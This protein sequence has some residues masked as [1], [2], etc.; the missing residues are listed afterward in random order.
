M[1]VRNGYRTKALMLGA[2]GLI[3][4]LL[5]CL[6]LIEF[7]EASE[8]QS[9]I[10]LIQ[11]DALVSV[12]LVDRVA[13]NVLREQILVGEHVFE[14][15]EAKM[16]DVE[17]GIAAIRADYVETARMYS[18]LA[19]FSGE[20]FAWHQLTADVAAVQAAEDT[21]LA[22][23][24]QNQD[25][26][27]NLVMSASKP[28][29]DKI[30][31]DATTLVDINDRAAVAAA[32]N[33]TERHRIDSLIQLLVTTG[34]LVGVVL[35]GMSIT[36][37][38][39]H[40][41]RDL[42]L[43]NVELENRNRELD[44][45]A[46]RIAHDLRSP[47]NTI[48]LSVEMMGETVPGA[49]PMSTSVTRGVTRIAR[50]IDDLLVLSRVGVMPRTTART[51]P[52]AASLQDDLGRIVAEH[53]GCLHIALE[54]AEVWC[55]EGLLRQV[56]WNL[57]ENAVKYR[58]P[59]SAP[60][61]TIDGK[62]TPG[63]YVIRVADNGLG[64]SEEDARH[65]FEPFYRSDQTSSIAGTGLGLAIVRRIVEASGGRIALATRLGHGSTFTITLPRPPS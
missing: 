30:D 2:F 46:G 7:H 22:L 40:G 36:R 13:M 28:L 59:D 44:A 65:A 17:R 1:R 12:R 54:P 61:I 8:V 39:L 64:M 35:G 14:R 23:S 32:R 5:G 21:A 33:A 6:Q 43:A 16:V 18:P 26:Q 47:L 62:V 34:I 50:L 31:Q 52:I 15:D 51:E 41:Q 58:R 60:T 25:V 56:L 19:S 38:V 29:F 45:F 11:K 48:S 27:A 55:A 49:K 37:V 53:Q 4:A 24:R 20:A 57:G 42:E 9:A 63:H 3:A 10:Q